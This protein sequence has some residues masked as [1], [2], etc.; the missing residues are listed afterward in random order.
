MI[1]SSVKQT[2]QN[3]DRHKELLGGISHDLRPPLTSIKAYVDGLLDEIADTRNPAGA[4][5]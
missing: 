1:K 4:I 5:Y 2:K 3:E